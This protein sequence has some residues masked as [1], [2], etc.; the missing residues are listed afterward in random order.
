[1]C[2]TA[3]NDNKNRTVYTAVGTVAGLHGL[4]DRGFEYRQG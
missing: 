1:V 3:R 4:D 2:K